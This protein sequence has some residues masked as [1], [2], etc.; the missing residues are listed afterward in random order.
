MDK[1]NTLRNLGVEI[2]HSL[3]REVRGEL[4]SVRVGSNRVHTCWFKGMKLNVV[5]E[6]YED[7]G[8]V[9]ETFAAE[10]GFKVGSEERWYGVGEL[11]TAGDALDKLIAWVNQYNN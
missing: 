7:G 10:L 11:D 4:S 6:K 3:T 1:I 5:R 9:D 2:P 8:T